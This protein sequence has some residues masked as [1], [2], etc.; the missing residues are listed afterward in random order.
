MEGEKETTRV[1]RS[2]TLQIRQDLYRQRTRQSMGKRLLQLDR[3]EA[4][5]IVS[6]ITSHAGVHYHKHNTGRAE[7][8]DYRICEIE[9]KTT[10]HILCGCGALSKIKRPTLWSNFI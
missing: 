6:L 1:D 10:R 3:Q 8:P 2:E 4:K 5:P 9:E 7:N